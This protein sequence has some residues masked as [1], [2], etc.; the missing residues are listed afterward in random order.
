[1]V[2]MP[3]LLRVGFALWANISGAFP[4][5]AISAASHFRPCRPRIIQASPE[6]GA[7]SVRLQTGHGSRPR[8]SHTRLMERMSRKAASRSLSRD[9]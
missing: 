6:S 1:M 4:S 2:V 5:G 8:R 3:D 9:T 7:P